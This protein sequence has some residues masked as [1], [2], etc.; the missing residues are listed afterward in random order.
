M[1]IK[2]RKAITRYRVALGNLGWSADLPDFYKSRLA[3]TR[4]VTKHLKEIHGTAAE[5][6]YSVERVIL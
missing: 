4:A 3:A 6:C 5:M 2:I 1:K